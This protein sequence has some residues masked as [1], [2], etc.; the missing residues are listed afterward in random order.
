M[1]KDSPSVDVPDFEDLINQQAR[2]NR[3][4]VSSPFGSIRFTGSPGPR[5]GTGGRQSVNIDRL[6]R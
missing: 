6:T 3:I 1:G 2:L 4:N 5:A